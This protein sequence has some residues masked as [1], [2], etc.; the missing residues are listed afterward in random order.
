VVALLA[1]ILV[2]LF[3][4]LFR[5]SRRVS[6]RIAADLAAEPAL[7][8]PEKALYRGGTGSYPSVTGNGTIALTERRLIFRILVGSDVEI[9]LSEVEDV[10]ESRVW[11]RSV[12][13][14]HTHL[15]VT[16]S[17]GA[18]GFYVGDVGAWHAAVLAAAHLD[19]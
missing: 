3:V 5:R 17:A 15:V 14:G 4:V 8:G 9:T 16:T 18:T 6:A 7:R 2:P 11:R 19:R 1:L 13:A 10:R 12:Q